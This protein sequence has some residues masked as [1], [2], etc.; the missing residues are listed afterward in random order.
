MTIT[1]VSKLPADA[2]IWREVEGGF[3]MRFERR[4]RHAPEKVWA[5]IATPEGVAHWFAIPDMEMKAGG[6]YDLRFNHPVNDSWTE[7]DAARVRP[8]TIRVYDPPRVFEHTF[9]RGVVRWEIQ[10]DGDGSWLVMTHSIPADDADLTDYLGGWTQHL[11]GLEAAI[12]GQ[13]TIFDWDSWR[14]VKAAYDAA[15]QV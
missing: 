8:N 13:T 6:R 3:E 5:A 10:P 15:V 7:E 9:G 1:T 2:G 12:A 4:L 14:A 11:R